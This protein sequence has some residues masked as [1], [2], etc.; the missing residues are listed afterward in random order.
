MSIGNLQNH[1]VF[2]KFLISFVRYQIYDPKLLRI[3][4]AVNKCCVSMYVVGL[5]GLHTP[6]VS[7]VPL[8]IYLVDFISKFN[9][10]V[11]SK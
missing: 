9:N 10:L 2:C 6:Y 4:M 11:I 1:V 3:G 5:F 8:Q 7:I